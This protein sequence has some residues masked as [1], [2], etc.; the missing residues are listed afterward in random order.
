M[1]PAELKIKDRVN[2]KQSNFGR[3]GPDFDAEIVALYPS[4]AKVR[5]AA[6]TVRS[7][8]YCDIKNKLATPETS[9]S[10]K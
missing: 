3:K 10:T 2:I 7:V 4:F 9:P 8:P 1:H 5:D 6:G